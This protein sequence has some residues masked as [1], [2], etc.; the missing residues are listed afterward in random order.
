MDVFLS[1]PLAGVHT[2]DDAD[3]PGDA[4]HEPGEEDQ[5]VWSGETTATDH[6]L[7]EYKHF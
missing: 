3:H 4:P 2:A 7:R 1:E 5:D 6:G